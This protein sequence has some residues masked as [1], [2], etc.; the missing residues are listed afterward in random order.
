MTLTDRSHGSTHACFSAFVHGNPCPPPTSTLRF[1]PSFLFAFVENLISSFKAQSNASQRSLFTTIH[2][3]FSFLRKNLAP[4]AHATE[5]SPQLHILLVPCVPERQPGAVKRTY[6]LGPVGPQ[7][8]ISLPCNPEDLYKAAQAAL[9]FYRNSCI[10]FHWVMNHR[11]FQQ[12]HAEGQW[13]TNRF[14]KQQWKGHPYI[15]PH[16]HNNL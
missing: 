4:N 15:L 13:T 7:P 10:G 6:N 2:T 3:N 9:F 14:L 5:F 11:V 8:I 1:L 12:T 16:L